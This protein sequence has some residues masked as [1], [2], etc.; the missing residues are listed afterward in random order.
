MRWSVNSH[1]WIRDESIGRF[2]VPRELFPNLLDSFRTIIP[3]FLPECLHTRHFAVRPKPSKPIL[4]FPFG[5]LQIPSIL[6][7]KP[8]WKFELSLLKL[9]TRIEF[10]EAM[11]TIQRIVPDGTQDSTFVTNSDRWTARFQFPTP[12]TH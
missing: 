2:L 4:K 3:L 9:V 12:E 11:P 7:S 5:G 8:F 6:R 1:E 10:R